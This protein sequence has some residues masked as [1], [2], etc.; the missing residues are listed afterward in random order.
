MKIMFHLFLTLLFVLGVDF[1]T[2]TWAENSLEPY[3]PIPIIGDFLRF[4]LGY[5]TGVAFGMFTGRAFL[6]LI[7]TSL[8]IVFLLIWFIQGL[9]TGRFAAY[10]VWPIGLLLGGAIGN[11]VDRF[12]NGQVTD[13]IDIGVGNLRWPTFNLADTFILTGVGLVVL[14]SFIEKADY[15]GEPLSPFNTATPEGEIDTLIT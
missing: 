14:L 3:Q 4:T 5:N 11:F 6:T 2:K 1:V 9:Y 7:I 13:F 8:V 10:A 15:R 12:L